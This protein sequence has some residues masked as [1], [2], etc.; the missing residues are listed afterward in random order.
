[1]TSIE[2]IQ[3]ELKVI[4]SQRDEISAQKMEEEK[5]AVETF[6]RLSTLQQE[7]ST[8]LQELSVLVK[9]KKVL[10]SECDEMKTKAQAMEQSIK[11]LET[12]VDLITAEAKENLTQKNS[13]IEELENMHLEVSK[14]VE[15]YQEKEKAWET[16]RTKASVDAAKQDTEIKSLQSELARSKAE[17]DLESKTSAE[18]IQ[19]LEGR[20][21]AMESAF[22][23]LFEK[24]GSAQVI[25]Q[26]QPEDMWKQHSAAVLDVLTYHTTECSISK[27]EH[28][29]LLEQMAVLERSS[30]A[31]QE[32]ESKNALTDHAGLLAKIAELEE[33]I[34]Q[35]NIQLELLEAEN[36][37][38]EAIIKALQDEY[39]Y[40]EKLIRDLSKNEDAGKEIARLEE[41]LRI[42]TN[43]TRETDEW[44][45]QVREDN[46]KYREAYLKADMSREETLL[47]MA[48]LHEELAESEQARLQARNQLQVEVN[49]LI[50]KH[51]LSPE[52]LSRLSKMNTESTQNLNL[53]QKVKQVA[54]LKEENLALKKKNISLANTRDSLRLKCLQI[55]RDLEGF[56]LAGVMTPPTSGLCKYSSNDAS[57][58]TSSLVSSSSGTIGATDQSPNGKLQLQGLVS[59]TPASD[60]RSRSTSPGSAKT[61]NG[62]TRPPLKSRAARS[63]MAGPSTTN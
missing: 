17:K 51:G 6:E 10:E 22:L 36:I 35:L 59:T 12:E 44:I 46:E 45:K 7:N 3:A 56:K 60:K 26:S 53:R 39:D 4:E 55:E 58:S 47:D 16:E 18:R 9:D 15:L 40:Q 21:R 61:S 20:C 19:D 34:R 1:M 23:Q 52:E 30:A 2:T 49:A 33:Q 29:E 41:E 11:S 50:K 24:S 8:V 25:D 62:A 42:L 43:R 37:G 63:Y 38:K 14:N 28:A 27:S 48:K 57:S 13:R 32:Q 54:Q 31:L 5:K